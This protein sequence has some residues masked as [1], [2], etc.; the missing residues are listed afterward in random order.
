[1]HHSE[2]GSPRAPSYVSG[3]SIPSVVEANIDNQS[4]ANGSYSR[5]GLVLPSRSGSSPLTD[6]DASP[7]ELAPSFTTE[8]RGEENRHKSTTHEKRSSAPPWNE[9]SRMAS[10]VSNCLNLRSVANLHPQ[11]TH[12]AGDSTTRSLDLGRYDGEMLHTPKDRDRYFQR[13]EYLRR[14]LTANYQRLEDLQKES[15]VAIQS[16]VSRLLCDSN[17]DPPLIYQSLLESR[18]MFE[19]CQIA[20]VI[21]DRLQILKTVGEQPHLSKARLMQALLGAAVHNWVFEEH[22]Q[23]CGFTRELRAKPEISTMFEDAIRNG[24]Y[25]LPFVDQ[26]LR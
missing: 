18:P 15:V 13:E 22:H 14:H 9:G 6:D 7:D 19:L 10:G 25:L 1:M 12:P 5:D 17:E 3:L 2:N 16:A 21:H 24:N 20:Y 4:P 11:R 8:S 23:R 26:K